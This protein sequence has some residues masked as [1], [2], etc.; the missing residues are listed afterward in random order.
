MWFG[1]THLVGSRFSLLTQRHELGA[2]RLHNAPTRR[3]WRCN[4]RWHAAAAARHH[5]YAQC[6]CSCARGCAGTA[7]I[8]DAAAGYSTATA[9]IAASSSAVGAAAAAA[10]AA[11]TAIPTATRPVCATEVVAPYQ[12]QQQQQRHLWR[13]HET[14]NP[15]LLVSVPAWLT[16]APAGRPGRRCGASVR[17]PIASAMVCMVGARMGASRPASPVWWCT[18]GRSY[19]SRDVCSLRMPTLD[20]GSRPTMPACC[21]HCRRS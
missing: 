21:C 13:A 19:C 3:A 8:K 14:C 7:T 15:L 9:A 1:V 18:C 5:A 12:Q 10:V 2:G 17:V 6:V 16:G 11:S 4:G 20:G